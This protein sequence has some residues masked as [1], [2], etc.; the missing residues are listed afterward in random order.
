MIWAQSISGVERHAGGL[1]RFGAGN[2][3][4]EQRKKEAVAPSAADIFIDFCGDGLPDTEWLGVNE[5]HSRH[6]GEIVRAD[7]LRWMMDAF[8]HYTILSEDGSS[9]QAGSYRLFEFSVSLEWARAFKADAIRTDLD[10]RISRDELVSGVIGSCQG[11]FTSTVAW[12]KELVSFG[13]MGRWTATI[14]ATLPTVKVE[15]FA[16]SYRAVL[17]GMVE[18]PSQFE[19]LSAYSR[20]L[21]NLIASSDDDFEHT[22][23]TAHAWH[24]VLHVIP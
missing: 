12:S 22:A 10:E 2:R 5:V 9:V 19:A 17:E 4:G 23:G 20:S 14:P 1:L 15:Q 6:N 21:G 8:D 7:T 24:T 18:K 3:N 13:S 11:N 16:L